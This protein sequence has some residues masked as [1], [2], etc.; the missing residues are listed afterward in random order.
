MLIVDAHED[1]AWNMLAF[2]RDYSRSVSQTRAREAEAG[3]LCEAGEA[4]LG[5]PEWIKGEVGIVFA[6]LYASPASSPLC[7]VPAMGY[8][9]NEE[10]H[11]LHQAQL[12]A[13]HQLVEIHS[14]KFYLITNQAELA[15]GL[16]QWHELPAE[17]RVGLVLLM[18]GADAIR[19][20]AEVA[21]W[22]A[23]GLRIVGPA[24]SRTRYAGGTG[25][26]GPLTEAG[27]SL[28]RHMAELGMIL[29]LSHMTDAGITE[30]LDSYPGPIIA[31]HSNARA[32]L[33]SNNPE[34]HLSDEMVRRLAE[35]QGVIGLVLFNEFLKD[36]VKM[37]QPRSVVTLEAVVAQVDHYCQ[38]VGH[39]R[40]LGLGSDFDGGF[41][42][43]DAPLGLDSIADLG[44]IGEALTRRGYPPADIAAIMGGN[45]LGLLSRVLP[46]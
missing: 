17:R 41:G 38:L 20:P 11:Q 1:I 4:L 27:R 7:G 37:G 29:D 10:A 25:N 22:H 44:R 33:P 36:G 32:L 46:A 30:A 45:W 8:R 19:Q 21:A 24:W 6:T 26:P 23:A 9:T 42:R 2:G 18:E 5:W 3:G 35:R 43:A 14:D 28:L 15:A 34:R 40:H 39:S 16:K 12:Q 31:S 13:Y